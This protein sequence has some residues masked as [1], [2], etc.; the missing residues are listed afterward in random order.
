VYPND[1]YGTRFANALRADLENDVTVTLHAYDP[2]NP[3]DVTEAAAATARDDPRTIAVFGDQSAAPMIATLKSLSLG[4]PGTPLFVDD[5]MR[6]PDVSS[7]S[8]VAADALEG[9]VGASPSPDPTSSASGTATSTDWYRKEFVAAAPNTPIDFS[10]YAY[11]CANLIALA[12]RIAGTDD[13]AHM[14]QPAI[15]ASRTPGQPCHDYADCS[16][17]LGQKFDIDLDGASGRID[18]DSNGDP[19]AG[20]FDVF[21]IQGGRDVSMRTANA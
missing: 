5:A 18:L 12:A 15:D 17:R 4:P 7:T 2:V 6:H 8:N 13:G 11:D 14:R 21:Q 20:Q 3:V 1:D 10:A 9:V 16:A 19:M